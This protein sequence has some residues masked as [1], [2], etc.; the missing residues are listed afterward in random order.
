MSAEPPSTA[1]G[2]ATP[3]RYFCHQCNRTVV[4]ESSTSGELACPICHGGFIEEFDAPTTAPNPD[5]PAFTL[6]PSAAPF[7]PPG[8]QSPIFLSRSTS[9]DLRDPSD[10]FSLI[11]PESGRFRGSD[12]GYYPSRLY[13]SDAGQFTSSSA[14]PNAFNPFDFLQRYIQ[15]MLG[16]A[17]V[18]V[19]L[20]GGDRPAVSFGDYFIGPGL[21][22]LIQQL[23][24]NDPNRYGTPPAAKTAIAS[25]PDV[26]IAQDQLASDEAQC[27]VCKESFEI[28]EMVKQLPCKHLFHKDCILPW[29]E[30]H[31]SCPVCRYELPTDDQDYEQR[32]GGGNQ[33]PLSAAGV[34]SGGSIGSSGAPVGSEEQNTIGQRSTPVERRFRINIPWLFR[35]SGSQADANSAEDAQG[36]AGGNDESFGGQGASGTDNSRRDLD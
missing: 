31:N 26:K 10:L 33:A 17:N 19:I 1:G 30:L 4:I 11:G 32:K 15:T 12:S 16:G 6:N 2:S 34:E 36:S 24:E 7:S 23:A 3:R 8:S 22:Q 14:G 13:G 35:G 9:F 28:E 18:Q 27:A 5:P 29:L 21:E 25:L 20:E